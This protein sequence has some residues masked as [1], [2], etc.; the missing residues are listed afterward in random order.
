MTE[1]PTFLEVLSRVAPGTALRTAVERIVHQG[2]GA[3]I[4]IGW[5]PEVES[6]ASGGFILR[7]S[8]FTPARLAELAKMDGAII[9]DHDGKMILRA[10]AH[11]LPDSSIRTEETG[12]RFRTAERMARMTD[13]PV[14]A[15]SEERGQSFLFYGDRK[16]RLSSPS[17][18]LVRMNQELQTMERF[19]RLLIEAEQ[20]LTGLEVND[21]ATLGDV[22]T[23]LQRTEMVRRIGNQVERLAIDLG[24][25]RHMTD[26]QQADLVSGVRELRE[27]VARDYFH[28]NGDRGVEVLHALE[29]KPLPDLYDTDRLCRL[30]GVQDPGATVRPM[31]H[32]IVSGVAGLPGVVRDNLVEHFRDARKI[33]MASVADLSMVSGV[34]EARAGAIRR[35]LDQIKRQY[36]HTDLDR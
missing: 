7:N 32:R 33:L 15:I 4:V 29:T 26:L 22:M 6:V 31:G 3:L 1:R 25:E 9:L 16:Q 2:T 14:L 11:L 27:M 5:D 28:E 17:E 18:L 12:A 35:Y 30:L 19:K 10:N 23:V 34:G 8:A 20:G 36:R 13:R 21:Q 24:E